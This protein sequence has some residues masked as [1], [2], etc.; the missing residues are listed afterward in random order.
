MPLFV[1]PRFCSNWFALSNKVN[2]HRR[3]LYTCAIKTSWRLPSI[4]LRFRFKGVFLDEHRRPR[5]KSSLDFVNSLHN[6]AGMLSSQFQK[7]QAD[8]PGNSSW[9][10]S[11]IGM[12]QYMPDKNT[13]RCANDRDY[14]SINVSPFEF[15]SFANVYSAIYETLSAVVWFALLIVAFRLFATFF[16]WTQI[17]MKTVSWI[18]S[19]RKGR[20][21]LRYHFHSTARLSAICPSSVLFTSLPVKQQNLFF[22]LS[23]ISRIITN[24]F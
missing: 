13:R 23:T 19:W 10:M 2:S 15:F 4:S 3:P 24:D 14:F 1:W 21:W 8:E 20:T 7:T 16:F 5:R 11:N 12:R 6:N 18:C 9:L 22:L 17:S